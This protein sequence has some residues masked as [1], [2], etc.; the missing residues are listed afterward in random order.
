MYRRQVYVPSENL[1]FTISLPTC[2]QSHNFER[3]QESTHVIDILNMIYEVFEV[4]QKI[5]VHLQQK[6][7]FRIAT[8]RETFRFLNARVIRRSCT[9]QHFVRRGV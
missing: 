8:V 5:I 2:F 7:D 6:E 3:T 1:E 9:L 4:S